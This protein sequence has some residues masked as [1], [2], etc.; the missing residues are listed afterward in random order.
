MFTTRR[1]IVTVR[2]AIVAVPALVGLAQVG[3]VAAPTDDGF[4]KPAR[5]SGAPDQEAA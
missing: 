5:P 1:R 4:P 2:L 3:V